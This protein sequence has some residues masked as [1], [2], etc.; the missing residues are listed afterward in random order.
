MAKGNKIK[1]L[2]DM[3]T[4]DRVVL[5]LSELGGTAILVFLGCMGCVTDITS[6]KAIPHEQISLTFGLAVMIAVQVFGHVS[7]SHI[8]PIV[9]VTAATLGHIALIRVPIYFVGQLLGALLGFS[10]LKIS[11]PAE[12]MGNQILNGTVKTPG[13]CSPGITVSPGQAFLVE[14]LATLI[15]A[16][17]CG[18]VW[19][20]RNSNKHD[21][22]PIRFGLTIAVLAMAAGPYTGAHMNPVRSFAPALFNGDWDHHWLY[23]LAPLSAGFFGGL[24]YRF[25]FSTEPPKKIEEA[26][27]S[28]PLND[29]AKA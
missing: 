23:W 26:V 6:A 28:I 29:H 5:C 27:E 16:L 19:D 2:D 9:T 18:G 12:Y 17:V 1:L 13:V 10:L 8:N 7:G 11:T 14:F 21:S 3:S 24:L 15:L 22:V 25:I 4:G 20:H